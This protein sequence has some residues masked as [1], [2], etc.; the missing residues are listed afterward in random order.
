MSIEQLKRDPNSAR[1]AS[2]CFVMRRVLQQVDRPRARHQRGHRQSSSREHLFEARRHRRSHGAHGA[3]DRLQRPAWRVMIDVPEYIF[4]A[5]ALGGM[6]AA[7]VWAVLE[8]K[9]QR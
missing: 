1:A 6:L 9:G 3:D 2:R 8:I 7:A 5:I 4:I